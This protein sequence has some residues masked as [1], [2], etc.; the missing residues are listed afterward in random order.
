MA[1]VEEAEN[2]PL[3]H[4]FRLV[5][6]GSPKTGKTSI[7]SRFLD[8]KF[9][10]VYTPTIEDFHRKVYRIRGEA[11]RLD[12]L[13]TSGNHPYPAMRRL[14]LLTGD[15]FLL[16]YSID[17]FESF[18]EVKCLR[19]Q[20]LETKGITP[21]QR[22][23]LLEIPMVVIGNKVDKSDLRV[24]DR[25]LVKDYC[26]SQIGVA[27]IEGSAKKDIN[28]E[29][30]F[31]KLFMMAHLPT[32]M[33]PSLHRKVTPNYVGSSSPKG[34]RAVGLRRKLSDACGAITPHVR[35]PSIRTDLM[36][37][38]AKQSSTDKDDVKRKESKCC[39]M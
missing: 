22:E 15:L 13:D 20:I 28:I 23:K 14:S 17:N 24:V 39:L 37:I 36:I 27:H 16:T 29:A 12:I 18:E 11:Y 31:L 21:N 32:E 33:S 38:Q 8:N 9:T 30:V 7:V 4:S 35:R 2:A 10:D 6:L 26:A 19:E 3:S 34:L 25:N 5:I 1:L